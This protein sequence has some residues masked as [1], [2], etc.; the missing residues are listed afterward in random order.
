[1]IF[2]LIFYHNDD[3]NKQNGRSIFNYQMM[4]YSSLTHTIQVIHIFACMTW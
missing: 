1:M 3:F 4:I 2:I